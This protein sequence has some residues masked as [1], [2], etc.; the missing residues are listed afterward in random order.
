MYA[1]FDYPTN[2]S[3]TL[4]LVSAI[5]SQLIDTFMRYIFALELE[6]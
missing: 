5:V 2:I 1:Y 4:N 3:F 6:R